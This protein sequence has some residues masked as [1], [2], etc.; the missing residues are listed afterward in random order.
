MGIKATIMT[1]K[2]HTTG[3]IIQACREADLWFQLKWNC[4]Q[5][6]ESLRQAAL[7][8][9]HYVPHEDI[10]NYL[11]GDETGSTYHKVDYV[12]QQRSQKLKQLIDGPFAV[13]IAGSILVYELYMNTFDCLAEGETSG[14]FD[15]SDCPPWGLWVGCIQDEKGEPYIL[16]WIPDELVEEAN[17]AIDVTMMNSL[18]WLTNLQEDWAMRLQQALMPYLSHK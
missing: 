14:L 18:S 4:H 10:Y 1:F 9:A 15:V 7:L 3:E 6:K 8:P 11:C 13:A 12:I 17:K 5:S 2:S 16:S